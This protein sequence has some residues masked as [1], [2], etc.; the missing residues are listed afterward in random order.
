M[1]WTSTGSTNVDHFAVLQSVSAGSA[2]TQVVANVPFTG[3]GQYHFDFDA[4]H[5][6]GTWSFGISPI[7]KGG[8]A[9]VLSAT[10]IV[11][12]LP[13][14]DV[15]PDAFSGLRFTVGCVAGALTVGFAY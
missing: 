1:S 8:N 2:A 12:L 9:G 7:D 11:V 5:G 3:D 13:P 14:K 10:A 4:V 15:T 6:P